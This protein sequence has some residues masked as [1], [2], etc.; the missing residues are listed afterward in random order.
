MEETAYSVASWFEL[1]TKYYLGVK[2]KED[3]MYGACGMYSG[4]EKCT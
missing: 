3:W 1:V 4:E 2:I